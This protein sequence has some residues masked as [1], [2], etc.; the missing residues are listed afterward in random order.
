MTGKEVGAP[1]ASAVRPGCSILMG[2]GCRRELLTPLPSRP[3]L[4]MVV[5]VLLQ[6]AAPAYAQS[7]AVGCDGLNNTF[8]PAQGG[9]VTTYI[10][11]GV[12][13]LWHLTFPS[14]IQRARELHRCYELLSSR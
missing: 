12:R 10:K 1:C 5:L 13:P 2:F 8:W 3:L 4:V 9:N 6:C 7:G 11:L 14:R